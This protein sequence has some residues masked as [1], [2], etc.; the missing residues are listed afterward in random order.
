MRAVETY[1]ADGKSFRRVLEYSADDCETWLRL[2]KGMMR[3][4]RFRVTA[5]PHMLIGTAQS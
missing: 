5:K 2:W 4:V 1:A 3:K